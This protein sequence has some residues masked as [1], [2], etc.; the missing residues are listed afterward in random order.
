MHHRHGIRSESLPALTVSRETQ[1]ADRA[2]PRCGTGALAHLS[3]RTSQR[4]KAPHNDPN[5]RKDDA[6]HPRARAS[7]GRRPAMLGQS[8]HLAVFSPDT[9][10]RGGQHQS[11]MVTSLPDPEPFRFLRPAGSRG[12]ADRR[13]GRNAEDAESA[14][15]HEYGV[16]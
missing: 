12:T 4:S 6:Q 10:Q 2:C 8:R 9:P 1:A 15:S 13:C 5:G 7:S 16:H 14:E 3:R 11:S